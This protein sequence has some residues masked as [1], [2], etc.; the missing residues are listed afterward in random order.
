MRTLLRHV[1]PIILATILGTAAYCVAL[2]MLWAQDIGGELGSVLFAAF[3]SLCIVYPLVYL[4]AFRFLEKKLGGV[5]PYL[6]FPCL[7]VLLGVIPTS[8]II[9]RW[10]GGIRGLLSPE[11]HLFYI[12]FSV[13]GVLLGGCFPLTRAA[14]TRST[15]SN[16]NPP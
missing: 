4:P 7:G 8:L 10:N 6:F 11:S 16:E 14:D 12:L 9:L 1:I 2:R 15:T 3:S 13:V 5:K